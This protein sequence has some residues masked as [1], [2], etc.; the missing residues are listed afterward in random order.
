IKADD[1]RKAEEV[2]LT[3]TAGGVMPVTKVDDEPIGN[4]SPGPLTLRLKDL[5]WALHDN[6]KYATPIA[7]D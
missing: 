3:S 4:G 6:P 7:Y 5:Y 2:F 1:L